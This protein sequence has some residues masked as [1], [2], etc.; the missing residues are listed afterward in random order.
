MQN[1]EIYNAHCGGEIG[2]VVI[3]LENFNFISP[4]EGSSF[5]F[6]D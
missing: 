4:K 6:K 2:D 3:G 1:I 5:L